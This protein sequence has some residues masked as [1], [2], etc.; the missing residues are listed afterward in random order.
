MRPIIAIPQMGND[1]FRR[2]MKRKYVKSLRQAGAAVRW[3]ELEDPEQAAAEALLCDGLLLPGGADIAPALYHQT[4]SAKCGEPNETRDRAEPVILRAFLKTGKPVL[5]ICRGVQLLNVFFN[6]TLLQDISEQQV[7]RHSDFRNRAHSSH[8]VVIRK[9][10]L[11]HRV[12]QT[13]RLAV[14]SMHHQ[15]VDRVGEGLLVSAVSTDGI[16]EA[17]E[18]PGHPFCLGVQWHPEHMAAR[19]EP[20]RK[21]FLAFVNA[22]GQNA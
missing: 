21:L 8:A 11:L 2:Y 14:N 1:L 13:D 9:D 5:C 6:G 18:L 3:V 16:I 4:P 22:C 15:A 12:L 7:Q 10:T 20:Q 17:L 19:S